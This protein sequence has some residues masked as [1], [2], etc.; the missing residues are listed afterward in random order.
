MTRHERRSR[1]AYPGLR[2][3]IADL[4]SEITL[5]G[6]ECAPLSTLDGKSIVERLERID[7][8]VAAIRMGVHVVRYEAKIIA[9]AET[10]IAAVEGVQA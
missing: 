7:R 1:D 6:Q 10:H 9:R 8:R 2:Q 3:R 4:Q 5:F